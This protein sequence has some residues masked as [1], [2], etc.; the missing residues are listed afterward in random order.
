M[1]LLESVPPSLGVIV[2]VWWQR[3]VFE[4]TLSILDGAEEACVDMVGWHSNEKDAATIFDESVD[5]VGIGLWVVGGP[6]VH[7]CCCAVKREFRGFPIQRLRHPY[8]LFQL[9]D[10]FHFHVVESVEFVEIAFDSVDAWR[11]HN[12]EVE[13][14]A[15]GGRLR[16]AWFGISKVG[17]LPAFDDTVEE[18]GQVGIDDFVLR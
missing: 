14:G 2:S 6:N 1:A 13:G 18:H 3:Y 4:L 11:G 17:V 8:V 16:L 5:T 7:K 15:F 10:I 12:T 9:V